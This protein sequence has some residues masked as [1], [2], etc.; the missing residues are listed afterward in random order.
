MLLLSVHISESCKISDPNFVEEFEEITVLDH[1]VSD[2]V[3]EESEETDTSQINYLDHDDGNHNNDDDDEKP[4][5][6]QLLLL[7]SSEPSSTSSSSSVIRLQVYQDDSEIPNLYIITPK[8][9]CDC[10]LQINQDTWID[11]EHVIFLIAS[12]LF[13]SD[14]GIE[15][16]GAK[17]ICK[18]PTVFKVT[19]IK[20][21]NNSGVLKLAYVIA[22]EAITAIAYR[23]QSYNFCISTETESIRHVLNRILLNYDGLIK[24]N[25]GD[26][27]DDLWDFVRLISTAKYPIDIEKVVVNSGEGLY[28]NDKKDEIV[29]WE[30]LIYIKHKELLELKRRYNLLRQEI[31]V[32]KESLTLESDVQV[33]TKILSKYLESDAIKFFEIQMKAAGKKGGAYRWSNQD[34]LFALG[35][36]YKNPSEYNVLTQR[37]PLPTVKTLNKFVA[38]IKKSEESDNLMELIMPVVNNDD[39]EDGSMV[40]KEN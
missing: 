4:S 28:L 13:K 20:L 29:R 25:N 9:N 15:E 27:N 32:L 35:I 19:N 39:T 17:L 36:L 40:K 16:R 23:I 31:D 38:T 30:K 3:D 22:M 2:G 26:N 7:S 37:Y 10:C 1:H 8:D 11:I 18:D 5:A 12:A 34:K 6:E 33:I 21:K 14:L 24:N